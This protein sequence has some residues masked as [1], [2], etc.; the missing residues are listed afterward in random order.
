MFPCNSSTQNERKSK[1]KYILDNFDR[2]NQGKKIFSVLLRARLTCIIL[3][4]K[5]CHELL[6]HAIFHEN[7][8]N[9]KEYLLS[10]DKEIIVK[11]YR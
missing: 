3:F 10:K 4:E 2:Q 6:N 7:F 1:K 8:S 11:N 9:I 5:T